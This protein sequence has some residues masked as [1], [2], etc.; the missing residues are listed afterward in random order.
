M[1]PF[2]LESVLGDK[3]LIP[4]YGVFLA[5]AF[6]LAYV[7]SV[8]GAMHRKLDPKHIENL[9]L[10]IVVSSVLGSRGFHV[11]FENFDYF[12]N[13][14]IEMFY[15]WQGGF[16]FYGA[17]LLCMVSSVSYSRWNKMDVPAYADIATPAILLGLFV[18]RIGCFFAGCCWGR[19]TDVFWGVTF[20]HPHTFA[21]PRGVPLHPTQLYESILCLF[22]YLYLLWLNR[23]RQYKGQVTA[24][25]MILYPI[26]R[27][28]V[29]GFR[30]D[31]YRGFVFGG[32]LSTSQFISVLVLILGVAM[33]WYW[34]KSAK[35]PKK[36]PA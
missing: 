9:F 32:L 22:I 28:F 23:R 26:A 8:V 34:G 3:V 13:H 6:T 29:E 25:A 19:P 30:G 11:L 5:F 2:L 17:L 10:I 16:T 18:G 33:C 15:F 36:N 21:S 31:A 27:I 7:Q 12:R 35:A 24:H 1:Y 14:P 4:M 20:N